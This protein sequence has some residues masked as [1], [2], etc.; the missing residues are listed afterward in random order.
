MANIWTERS[1][2]LTKTCLLTQL[3]SSVVTT[4]HTPNLN[5]SAL[6]HRAASTPAHQLPTR[7]ASRGLLI[8]ASPTLSR[9]EIREPPRHLRGRPLSP[10]EISV[11]TIS[12]GQG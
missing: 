11:P 9:F 12:V 3:F 4:G 7:D 10:D 1:A 6:G 2:A 8:L 5:S